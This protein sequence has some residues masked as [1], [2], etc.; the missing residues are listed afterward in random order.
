M[1]PA[2]AK[3]CYSFFTRPRA[4]PAEGG[5]SSVAMLLAA[6]SIGAWSFDRLSE[7]AEIISRNKQFESGLIGSQADVFAETGQVSEKAR[8]DN[9]YAM[10]TFDDE[11][12]YREYETKTFPDSVYCYPFRGKLS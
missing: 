8:S 6:S 4:T 3:T 11:Q 1:L 10:S 7:T 5:S 2:E 12:A 9:P